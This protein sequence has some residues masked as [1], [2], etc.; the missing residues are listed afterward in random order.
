VVKE[1]LMDIAQERDGEVVI[2]RLKGRFDSSGAPAVEEALSRA[3]GGVPPRLAIDMGGLDYISSAGLRV[4]L[5]L[6]KKVQ[7]AKGKVT[8]CGLKPNVRD[9]FTVSGFDTIFSIHADPAS[10]VAAAC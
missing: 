5:V 3:L 2:V 10:A 1:R 8:L 7:Q 6:A 9:V 4:L